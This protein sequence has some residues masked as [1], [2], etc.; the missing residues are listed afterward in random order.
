MDYSTLIAAT[1]AAGS[2]ANWVMST[3]A[4]A[5]APTIIQEAESYIYRRL[6]HYLMITTTSGTMTASAT[7]LAAPSDFL[8]DKA[9][10]FTGT[11]YSKLTRKPL[12]EVLGRYSYDGTGARVP[13]KP[14]IYS[15]AGTS[16]QFDSPAYEAYP[17]TLWYYQQP[18]ALSTATATNFITSRYP[19]LMRAACMTQACEFMKDAGV[20]N[21]E[22]T[23]WAQMTEAEIRAAEAETDRHE[24]ST[25]AGMVII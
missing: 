12:Q 15:D 23:Y 25:E 17:F 3:A 22:R 11:A 5:E 7:A 6:R 2:I 19:R 10:Y 4:Q 9:F 8:E 24:R 14:Q 21:Y 20:G 1:T 13:A 18:P 16:I